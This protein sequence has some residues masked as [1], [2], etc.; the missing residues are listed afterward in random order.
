MALLLVNIGFIRTVTT[1]LQG[2][3]VVKHS[4]TKKQKNDLMPTLLQ[5]QL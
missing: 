4:K 2:P 5:I 3:Y 1:N